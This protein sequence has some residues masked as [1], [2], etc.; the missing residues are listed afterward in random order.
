[1]VEED[2]GG[3][4]S[5]RFAVGRAK[6]AKL[7]TCFTQLIE[8]VSVVAVEVGGYRSTG[9]FHVVPFNARVVEELPIFTG[10]ADETAILTLPVAVALLAIFTL[11][12][13]VATGFSRFID[14]PCTDTDGVFA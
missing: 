5:R 9:K 7:Y 2:V 13:E 12:D 1:M 10:E 4:K 6:F 11:A 8:A 3:Y 14:N